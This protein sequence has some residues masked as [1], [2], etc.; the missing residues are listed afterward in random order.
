MFHGY[1]MLF[2]H[3]KFCIKYELHIC[4]HGKSVTQTNLLISSIYN[5]NGIDNFE[6]TLN[7]DTC[8]LIDIL[9]Y[10][11][12]VFRGKF[13]KNTLYSYIKNEIPIVASPC[14]WG[15]GV[16]KLDCFPCGSYFILSLVWSW[17]WRYIKDANLRLLM[18]HGIHLVTWVKR[19][20]VTFVT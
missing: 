20:V 5:V 1:D 17:F 7:E 2:I 16:I 13:S 6:S 15:D 4:F 9:L 10:C 18:M 12:W 19:K 11:G 14:P 3:M 8:I